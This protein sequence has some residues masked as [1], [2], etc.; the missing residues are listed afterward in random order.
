M[1]RNCLVNLGL[2]VLEDKLLF[3][4]NKDKAY[5]TISMY[6]TFASILPLHQCQV[7]VKSLVKI[8]GFDI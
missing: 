8:N 4:C 1:K 2:F 3:I 5:F 7:C 6:L